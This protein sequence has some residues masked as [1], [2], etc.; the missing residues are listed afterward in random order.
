[1]LLKKGL[2][3]GWN[4]EVESTDTISYRDDVL[5]YASE[6]YGTSAE[7]LWMKAPRY[8][9]LRHEDNNKWYGLIMDVQ[10]EK[11][12]LSG[13]GF[14]DVL[15]IKCDPILSGS[16]LLDKG[17]LP[18]YHMSRGNWISVLLDGSIEKE[19]VFSLLNMSFD[20]TASR[21]SRAKSSRLSNRE[22]IVPA[23][24]KYFDLEEAFAESDTILW[25][26]SSNIIVGD[27]IYLYVT[28]PVSAIQYKCRAVEV[29][30][31]YEYDDGNVHMN[32]V[33]KIQLLHKFQK[34]QLDFKKLNEFGVL[35]VRGPRSVPN[36]L[37]YEIKALCGEDDSICPK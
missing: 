37:H 33:M 4:K 18:A 1:M 28:A 31:P 7:Y 21:K 29:D 3:S 19:K 11:L 26:Q 16:L 17:I 13:S 20:N 27:I 8:A 12:G 25:K 32:R 6:Q 34:G 5:R 36:S 15:E 24:P 22:W 30:V 23:N 9:V 35:A 14:V 2:W 10:R